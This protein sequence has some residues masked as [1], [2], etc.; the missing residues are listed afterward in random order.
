MVIE[1]V[2]S[3]ENIEEYL[4]VPDEMMSSGLVTLEKVRVVQYGL[5]DDA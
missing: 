5:P 4:P 2:D 1:I 3:E